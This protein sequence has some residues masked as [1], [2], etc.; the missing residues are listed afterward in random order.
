MAVPPIPP[1]LPGVGQT[2]GVGPT[3]PSPATPGFGDALGNGIRAVSDLEHAADAAIE[4]VASGGDTPI[5]ELMVQT[6]KAEVGVQLLTQVRDRAVEAYQE[7][8]RMQV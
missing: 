7:I 8:M 2:P 3:A 1:Q 6:T 5:H 4:D